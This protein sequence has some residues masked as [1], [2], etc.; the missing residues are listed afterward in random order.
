MH[1][2]MNDYMGDSHIGD[3]ILQ[4]IQKWSGEKQEE[5]NSAARKIRNQM[6][7]KLEETTPVQDYPYNNGVVM[8]ITVH[9]HGDTP[10]VKE[11]APAYRQPGAMAK[12]WTNAT[13]K[14]K[15]GRFV[16]GV[17]NKNLPTVVH[18]VNFDHDVFSHK[19]FTGTVYHGTG[20]VDKVQDWGQEELDKEIKQILDK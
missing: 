18:L 19:R 15:S 11:P 3:A 7:S 9:R 20:F 10:A 5:I 1:D 2:Y 13:L 17:R 14:N 8:Q 6:K 4:D 12:G 16:I